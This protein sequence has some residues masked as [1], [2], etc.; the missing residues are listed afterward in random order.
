MAKAVGRVDIWISRQQQRWEEKKLIIN[1][2]SGYAID[3]SSGN[4][5]PE[6]FRPTPVMI[7]CPGNFPFMH[8]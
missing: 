8:S 2:R 1:L 3:I 4:Q 7:A 6:I 5:G